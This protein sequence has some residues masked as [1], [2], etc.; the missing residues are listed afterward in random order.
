LYQESFGLH[1]GFSCCFTLKGQ[2]QG[3]PSPVG[4]TRIALLATS[5][6]A[7]VLPGSNER[8]AATMTTSK[9]LLAMLSLTLGAWGREPFAFSKCDLNQ[10]GATNVADVQ[11]MRLALLTHI[12]PAS[13]ESYYRGGNYIRGLG[14]SSDGKLLAAGHRPPP[15]DNLLHTSAVM[16]SRRDHLRP[17]SVNRQRLPN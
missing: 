14:F 12:P 13:G 7:L 17:S 15:V 9:C 6:I 11:S 1:G 5:V 8:Y 2:T 4:V 10:D 16:A 3:R